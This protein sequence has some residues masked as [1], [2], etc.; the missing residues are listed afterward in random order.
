MNN[1]VSDEYRWVALVASLIGFH[2]TI[3]GFVAG[4][5]R[6][7]TFTPEIIS[8]VQ[9]E[10][11]KFFPGT[12]INKEGYPDMGNGRYSQKLSYKDWYNFN[13][14]QRAHYN[15]LEC[16]TVV[17]TWLL[18]AGVKYE[19]YAVGFGSAFL[20]GRL[21]YAFGYAAKG[22]QGRVIGFLISLLASLALCVLAILSS[23]R[24][25]N[26]Y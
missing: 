14:A 25:A 16:A 19:W 2:L 20:L 15:Y 22:P 4:G 18:I 12:Q 7:A 21:M 3:T 9:D 17:I 23:L 8:Q 13:N 11:E 24:L 10:H 6:K 5:K 1:I 26:V